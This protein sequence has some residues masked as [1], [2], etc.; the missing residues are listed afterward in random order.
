MRTH[1]RTYTYEE[2][3]LALA[4][5]ASEPGLS[6]EKFRA[7][8]AELREAWAEMPEPSRLRVDTAA[9]ILSMS[10]AVIRTNE[11]RKNRAVPTDG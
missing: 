8:T 3:A 11:E 4:L 1:T 7:R 10:G 6:D 5:E 9:A 2:R